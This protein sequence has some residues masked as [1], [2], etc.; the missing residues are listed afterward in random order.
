[1][2][3]S[4]PKDTSQYGIAVVLKD[5]DIAYSE[6]ENGNTIYNSWSHEV[7]SPNWDRTVS[8]ALTGNRFITNTGFTF[9]PSDYNMDWA[10]NSDIIYYYA[11]GQEV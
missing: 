10:D 2:I 11:W 8:G 6:D 7:D 4:R 1:M 9:K 3:Y 5:S